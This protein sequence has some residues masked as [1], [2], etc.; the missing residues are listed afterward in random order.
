MREHDH[1]N[2]LDKHSLRHSRTFLQIRIRNEEL[3]QI[4]D[5]F[6]QEVVLSVLSALLEDY[7]TVY[8]L[9]II[10]M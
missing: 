9:L 8:A 5:Q 1:E 2:D 10:Y 7:T 4:I 6:T 3:R